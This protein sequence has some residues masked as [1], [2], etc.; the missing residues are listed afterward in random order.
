VEGNDGWDKASSILISKVE[1]ERADESGR[2][3]SECGRR[4]AGCAR[5]T[6]V[7]IMELGPLLLVGSAHQI[8]V[9]GY[10][11]PNEFFK[12]HL[13]NPAKDSLGLGGVS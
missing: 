9:G 12:T 1:G 4:R 5:V 13:W 7:S 6:R 11:G 2:W 8:D 3:G 10:H